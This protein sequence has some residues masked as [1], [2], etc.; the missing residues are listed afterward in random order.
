MAR[1]TLAIALCLLWSVPALAQSAD[2][3]MQQGIE[4]REGRDDE[5][6]L[7]LFERAHQIE[8]SGETFAQ[9]ALAQQAL[10]RFVNAEH[11]LSQALT[12]RQDRFI[13]RN[14][15]LLEQAL[16][17]I[18][19]NI[20]LVRVSGGVDGA[21][22]YVDGREIG[23]LPRPDAIRVNAGEV[24]VVARAPGYLP[25]TATVEVPR[26]GVATAELTMERE[27]AQ[28]PPP[29]HHAQ[30]HPGAPVQE[31]LI[32]IGVTSASLGVLG[33]I[34]ATIAMVIRENAAVDRQSCTDDSIECRDLFFLATEAETTGIALF[35][36]SGIL[37]ATGGTLFFI[38][39]DWHEP[40][41]EDQDDAWVRCAPGPL[42]VGCAGRF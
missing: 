16:A 5:R 33:L 22:L 37:L 19:S 10:G 36:A 3:L 4:A 39:L 27:P 29:V 28:P 7:E 9:M 31:L 34:G 1:T 23:A 17:E 15:A 32:G 38:G 25:A 42:S 35:I 21:M 6:A 40:E 11:N 2:D 41:D 18:R 14:R 8:P 20:G 30:S 13:R 26:E 12:Y 24:E